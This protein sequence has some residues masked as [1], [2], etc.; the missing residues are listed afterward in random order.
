MLSLRQFDNTVAR[1][2]G[3]RL[4]PQSEA[5]EHIPSNVLQFAAYPS[6]SLPACIASFAH[7]VHVDSDS[8]LV[9]MG[10]DAADVDS[11]LEEQEIEAVTSTPEG[12]VRFNQTP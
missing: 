7:P 9:E 11:G 2:I 4:G 6:D 5:R 8:D 1:T 12:R 10:P 3:S